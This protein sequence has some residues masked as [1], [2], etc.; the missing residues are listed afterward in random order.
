[1]TFK[2]TPSVI[3]SPGSGVGPSPCASPAGRQLLLFGPGAAPVSPSHRRG[4]GRVKPTPATSGPSF[5]DSPPSAA[6]QH[7]LGNRLRAALDVN[8]SPEYVLTWKHW[9]MPSGPPICALRGSVRRTSANGFTG[10]LTGWATPTRG[11]AQKVKPFH[12]APQPALAYQ[13][14]LAGWPTCQAH[15]T[16]GAKTPEQ[17]IAA[18]AHARPRK[19][20]G[21]PGFANL[22]EVALLAGWTTP[23][24]NEPDSPERPSRKETGRTTEYLGRQV[25]GCEALASGTPTTSSTAATTNAGV[26]NPAHSR[27]LIGLPPAWDACAGT[28]MPLCRKSQRRS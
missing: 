24:A 18:K 23:Q 13:C 2:D 8:G 9:V 10:L 11:D 21:P 27:W 19:G 7:C 16:C 6:L 3:S 5:F 14:H 4:G 12:D 25:Q 22:N 28:A 15:D 26:L 1:M 17:I 20:G